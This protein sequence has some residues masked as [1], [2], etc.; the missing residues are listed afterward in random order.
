M[1][2]FQIKGSNFFLIL[3]T[4][5]LGIL[6]Y[7]FSLINHSITIDNETPIYN[8]FAMAF[9][10]WGQ[11]IIVYHIFNGHQ[12]FFTTIISLFIFSLS[13][14]KITNLLNL[15]SIN[16]LIFCGLFI[17][18]PQIS[19]QIVFQIMAIIAGLGILFS[20]YFVDIYLNNI[21]NES[22]K[23]KKIIFII[24]NSLL[25]SFTLAMYQAF[26]IVPLVLYIIIIYVNSFENKK[27]LKIEF[28][29]AFYFIL[30]IFFSVILYIIS[31]KIFCVANNESSYLA[32]FLSGN[33]ENMFG[34]F[35]ELL[36]KN[37]TGN[38]YYGESNYIIST[39]AILGLIFYTIIKKNR[40]FFKLLL[41]FL[42]LIVPF[43]IS[44]FITNGYHPPRLYL[45]SNL[46]FAFSIAFFIEKIN[47]NKFKFTNYIVV[48][49][50]FLNIYFVTNLY[51]KCN[52]I[53]LTDVK[54]AEKI[55]GIITRLNPDFNQTEKYV[56]F[57]G[58]LPY[59]YHQKYRVENSEVFGGS[60]FSWDNGN[61]Y[62][63]INFIREANVNEY[64]LVDDK[65]IYDKI[66]QETLKNM[67]NWPDQNSI[68]FFDNVVVVKLGT[69]KG[70]LLPFE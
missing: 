22:N 56:Y 68:R 17:T 60:F 8:D 4:F 3:L 14:V 54:I 21:L 63:I 43:I 36:N 34:N 66:N 62:R 38:F 18:F 57:H 1:N 65:E 45:T 70:S 10:R 32:S 16:K 28:L 35:F 19:Y 9:G 25:F 53:Y 24:I 41:L 23:T 49:I 47:L 69:S 67:P 15:N 5:A 30:I 2:N 46:V 26:I 48:G 58:A 51:Q 31:V 12:P 6:T 27:T 33:N 40:V 11:N 61:N 29:N 64:N 39:I 13:A 7:G 37:L 52:K 50:I 42:I 20:V 55:D 59:D 44:F